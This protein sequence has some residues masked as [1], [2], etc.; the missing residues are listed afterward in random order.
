M[1][2]HIVNKSSKNKNMRDC[3]KIR[4]TKNS[5]KKKLKKKMSMEKSI[6]E[7]FLKKKKRKESICTL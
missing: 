2:V 3:E 4:K 5:I 6:I 7:I 1:S